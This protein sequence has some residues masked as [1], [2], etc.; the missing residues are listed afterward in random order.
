MPALLLFSAAL[1]H[2]CRMA[3]AV[4][5]CDLGQSVLA[6]VRSRST[7][8]AENPFLRERLALFQERKVIPRRADDATRWVMVT[9][10]HLFPWRGALVNVKPNTFIGWH[11][12]GLRLIRRWKSKPTGR[13]RLPKNLRELIREMA[14]RCRPGVRNGSPTN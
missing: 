7:L 6:V 8:A 2:C 4:L 14:P 13:P 11:H 1:Q 5:L 9:L 3:A 12:K 10:S